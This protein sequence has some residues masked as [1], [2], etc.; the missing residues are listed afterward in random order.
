MPLTKYI[1]ALMT[2]APVNSNR[3]L[4]VA[5]SMAGSL[6]GAGLGYVLGGIGGGF[7]V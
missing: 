4:K 6:E 5:Y 1:A 7:H 2:E 3:S